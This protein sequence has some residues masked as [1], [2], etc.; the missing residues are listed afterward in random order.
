[1]KRQPVLTT[2][3]LVLRPLLMRDEAAVRDLAGS[4]RI[5]DLCLWPLYEYGGKSARRWIG[6]TR[7]RWTSGRGAEFAIELRRSGR[8]VGLIG[9]DGLD[10]RHDSA[11]LGFVLNERHWGN[12]YATEAAVVVVWFGVVGLKLNRIYA[13][14]LAS[15]T[16]SAR[17]LTNIGMKRE[18]MLREFARK[19]KGFED[20][21]MSAILRREWKSAL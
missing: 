11:E 16:A 21:V 13:R 3:R 17:V 18:G 12:H 7:K 15:N 2:K 1:M 8:M 9:L 14:H 4:K 19:P 5:A 6:E 10:S 20:A